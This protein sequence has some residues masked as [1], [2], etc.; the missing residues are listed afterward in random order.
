M[1]DSRRHSS[2]SVLVRQDRLKL[3]VP[4]EAAPPPMDHAVALE[5]MLRVGC[6]IPLEHRHRA[7]VLSHHGAHDGLVSN[8]LLRRVDGGIG[9]PGALNHALGAVRSSGP[10][11]DAGDQELPDV[12]PVLEP[13]SGRET[14]RLS[15]QAPGSGDVE[16]GIRRRH[17]PE[18]TIEEAVALWE[19]TGA[20]GAPPLRR[21][22]E[23]TSELQSRLHLVCRLL[24]E[25]KK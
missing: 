22:E 3:R 7:V 11:D 2:A 4:L 17:E 10:T 5:R 1:C 15:P 8:E 13:R 25:K 21:S 23:H 20:L 12:G 19:T 24:L 9:A 6:D 18:L 14:V 16:S